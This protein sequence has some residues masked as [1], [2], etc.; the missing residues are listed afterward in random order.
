MKKTKTTHC[1]TPAC[2]RQDSVYIEPIIRSIAGAL[3]IGLA[4]LLYY[5]DELAMLWLGT[6]IFLG[7]N[8]LQSGF[9]GYCMMEKFLKTLRLTSELDEIKTLSQ[10][11]KAKADQQT[12]Y[13]D[14]LKLLNE[15][16][17]EISTDGD[18]LSASEGWAK[19]I[20]CHTDHSHV[21]RKLSGYVH[22]SD[23]P[24]FNYLPGLLDS[25][26]D[27]SSRINFRLNTLDGR[28]KWV[29][30]NFLLAEQDG[31]QIIK[32]VLGDIS[33][34][35]LLE[36]EHRKFKQ[37]LSHARRLSSLGEMAAGL[38][39]ELNQPLAA[40]NLYVQ[41]CL[42]R[43]DTNP[44]ETR[45]ISDAMKSASAQAK[46]AGNIIQ[47]VRSFV[48]KAPLNSTPTDL[49][50]LLKDA[51]Q[52]LDIDPGAKETE[53]RYEL[54]NELP[55]IPLDPLQIKQVLVNLV[56]NAIESMH[57]TQ[58]RKLVT[59]RTL[60][61]N[62][63]VTIEVEDVGTGVPETISSQLFEPFVTGQENGLGLGLTICQSIVEQHGGKLWL[64]GSHNH[65]SCFSFTLPITLQ[66]DL[67]GAYENRI[68]C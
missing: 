37:E 33:Q 34:I 23:R 18:L 62:D 66:E 35:R 39:H 58:N 63:S 27:K 22:E 61:L 57:G 68:H 65:G 41:G 53:F 56:Q 43:L 47:Q 1:D 28:T 9:S 21:N 11:L 67:H 31:R 59:L 13:L 5:S 54:D 26:V 25:Q 30:A 8:L 7:F 6:L 55:S 19:L 36:D 29:S 3:I 52:L 15:A 51:I 12:S 14:T 38:A 2:H 49:N 24:L 45:E 16:V 60:I 32:G 10:E 64:K 40:I 48:R 17:I 4:Y 46:R 42:Q 50:T 20:E 44:Q